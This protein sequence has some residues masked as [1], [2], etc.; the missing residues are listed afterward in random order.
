MQKTLTRLQYLID[1]APALLAE[2]DDAAF[3]VKPKSNKWSK[4]EILG[5]LIDSATNNH[6]RFVRTQFEDNPVILYDQ[7]AWCT[8]NHYNDIKGSQIISLWIAYNSQLLELAKRIPEK[9]LLKKANGLT[10]EFL[11][12]DYVSHLEHHL[13]QIINC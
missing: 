7:D 13:R 6:H 5:H 4:K 3:S 10:L 8:F 1:T 12:K 2:I 11:I 9:D